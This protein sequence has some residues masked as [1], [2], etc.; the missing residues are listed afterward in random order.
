MR[1]E[2]DFE[3]MDHIK[4]SLNGNEKLAALATNNS[5]AICSK[6]LADVLTSGESYSVVKDWN[7]NGEQVTIAIERV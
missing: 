7:V 4:V 6:V 3:V 5:D 2:A 1:K